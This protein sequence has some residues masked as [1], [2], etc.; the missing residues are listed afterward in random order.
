M[1]KGIVNLSLSTAKERETHSEDR[2]N[3]K[4]SWWE[5]GEERKDGT[6][7]LLLGGC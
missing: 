2:Y 3:V 7:V 5:A 1:I 4:V 6:F